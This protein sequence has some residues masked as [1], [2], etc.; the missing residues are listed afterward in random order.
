MQFL[1]TIK[2]CLYK[3]LFTDIPLGTNVLRI[4]KAKGKIIFTLKQAQK[5]ELDCIEKEL[6]IT[7]AKEMKDILE[8]LGYK[9]SVHVH[10]TRLKATLNDME[11]CLDEVKDL[12]S[13]IE[14]EKLTDEVD[15]EKV[16][17]ELFDFLQTVGVKKED[18]VTRGYDTLMWL[19]DNPQ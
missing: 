2:D 19:K 11:I 4:R 17:N 3:G 5:N 10:K 7:N 1:Q 16:Q 12:G 14:V 9:E 6:E 8:I 13:F 18:R 15:G